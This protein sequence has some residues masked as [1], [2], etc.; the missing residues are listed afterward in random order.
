M[1]GDGVTVD[2]NAL[3]TFAQGV[4]S[5]TVKLAKQ[6]L[7]DMP[8]LRTQL[9]S[10]TSML[11]EGQSFQR[12]HLD[13]VAQYAAFL[14]D[15]TAGAGALADGADTIALNLTGTDNANAQQLLRAALAGGA[16]SS[17]LG[18]L[19]VSGPARNALSL[20]DVLDAFNPTKATA[21][22][23]LATLHTTATQ[24]PAPSTAASTAANR[25]GGGPA[26]AIQSGRPPAGARS[27]AQPAAAP[28][29][30]ASRQIVLPSGA[31]VT[32]PADSVSQTQLARDG[33]LGGQ[34][35]TAE[36]KA[37]LNVAYPHR[38]DQAPAKP[39][40]TSTPSA[41]P[42]AAPEP[43]SSSTASKRKGGNPTPAPSAGPAPSPQP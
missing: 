3:N 9:A 15:A 39:S 11:S 36:E 2:P 16:D 40:G 20:Q 24:S 12:R 7:E 21:N 22:K 18:L 6:A 23:F 34:T 41:S 14:L 1:A 8:R 17:M 32:V 42:T 31:R 30:H 43:E 25:P 10:A 38:E 13:I 29:P 5:T 28:V 35:G 19:P 27:P 26:G 37:L 33:E 4:G